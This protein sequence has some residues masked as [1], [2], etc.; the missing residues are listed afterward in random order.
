MNEVQF[1]DLKIGDIFFLADMEYR[2]TAE[3]KISCCKRLNAESVSDP[4]SKTQVN[5]LTKV[6]IPTQ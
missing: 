1:K 2:K 3:K 5:P 4:R 6:K